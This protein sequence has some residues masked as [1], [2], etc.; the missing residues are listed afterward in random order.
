MEKKT[1]KKIW[2]TEREML[3]HTE[4]VPA[5]Q[6]FQASL[7]QKTSSNFYSSYFFCFCSKA[8]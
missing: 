7:L 4:Y 6:Y 5:Y 2:S 3:E 1:K 8:T